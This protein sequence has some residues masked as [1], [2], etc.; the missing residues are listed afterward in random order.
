VQYFNYTAYFGKE[1]FEFLRLDD[2]IHGLP[3]AKLSIIVYVNEG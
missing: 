1:P 3:T 2:F